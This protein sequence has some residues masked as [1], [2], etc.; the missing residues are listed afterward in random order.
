MLEASLWSLL[1]LLY[2]C[3]L[4]FFLKRIA[5]D[6]SALE[7]SSACRTFF[8]AHHCTIVVV[9]TGQVGD[10]AFWLVMCWNCAR[11]ALYPHAVP[12][13]LVWIYHKNVL[14][15]HLG[16]PFLG[17]RPSTSNFRRSVSI[18]VLTSLG[19]GLELVERFHL[20][21]LSFNSYLFLMNR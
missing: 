21:I 7:K 18:D 9:W 8:S 19:F 15:A 20:F 11:K 13:H 16:H 6:C 4:L 17:R 3:L 14:I 1:G 12:P 2:I 10:K 5:L